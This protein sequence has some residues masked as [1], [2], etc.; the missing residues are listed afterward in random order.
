MPAMA[1]KTIFNGAVPEM[2]NSK[3]QQVADNT[4]E[5]HAAVKLP[6]KRPFTLNKYLDNG[7][8]VI[9][10]KSTYNTHIED[11]GAQRRKTAILEYQALDGKH[12]RH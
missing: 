10:E 1:G 7:V 8:Y 3:A 12:R 11:I 4:R 5:H 6:T 2:L 9:S